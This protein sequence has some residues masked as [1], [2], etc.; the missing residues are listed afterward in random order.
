M[1]EFLIEGKMH[2]INMLLK[3]DLIAL[4]GLVDRREITHYSLIVDY[5]EC[6]Y[7]KYPLIKEFFTRLNRLE[8]RECDG[9]NVI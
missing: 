2:S 8:I 9:E 4:A 1:G 5:L 3:R 7:D 6:N